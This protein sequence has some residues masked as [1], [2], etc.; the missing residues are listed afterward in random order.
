MANLVDIIVDQSI[1]CKTL[2]KT[3]PYVRRYRDIDMAIS[4]QRVLV[5][6]NTI[7]HADVSIN[8]YDVY[9]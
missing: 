5:V 4:V 9:T 7:D 6:A 3:V 8:S 2:I 1:Y